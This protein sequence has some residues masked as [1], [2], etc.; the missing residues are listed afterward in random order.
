MIEQR[1]QKGC[2]ESNHKPILKVKEHT[3][4][5]KEKTS[6]QGTRKY[7]KLLAGLRAT[8]LIERARQVPPHIGEE[9]SAS[10]DVS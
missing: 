10:K 6:A 4:D 7:S 3:V 2:L 5:L 9:K 8:V 1:R